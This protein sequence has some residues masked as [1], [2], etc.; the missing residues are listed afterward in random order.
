MRKIT[1]ALV[2]VTLAATMTAGIAAIAGCSADKTGEAYALVHGGSYVG[3]SKIVTNGNMVK[4]LEL[5]E[6]CLPTQITAGEGVAEA[7]KVTAKVNDHG[8]LVDKSFYK[9]IS[10]ADITLTY[11]TVGEV[12]GYYTSA[13]QTLGDYLKSEKNAKAYYEAV[14]T[15]SIKVTVGGEQKT[16]IMNNASLNKDENGY[17]T[18]TGR[19][20][21]KYSR[22]KMNRDATVNYVKSYGLSRLSKLAKN[23]ESWESDAKEDKA[24]QTWMDGDISTGATWSDLNSK[25]E[26]GTYLSYAQLILKA[27]DAAK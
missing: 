24:V 11:K 8:S 9:T 4:D 17:W 2:G 27:G 20:G 18:R 1:K 25:P 10:Y 12:S 7:D 14:T 15:N 22:W 6:V 19:D 16:D 13:N 3:Y 5:H 21:Q 26:A 23:P